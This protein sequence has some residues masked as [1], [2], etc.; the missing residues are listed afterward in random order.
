MKRNYCQTE[1]VS[2]GTNQNAQ[3]NSVIPDTSSSK[4]KPISTPNDPTGLWTNSDLN[5]PEPV[6]EPGPARAPANLLFAPF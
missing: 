3:G 5:G 4:D 2:S 1:G 6:G